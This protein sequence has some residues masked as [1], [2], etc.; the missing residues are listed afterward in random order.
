MSQP[1]KKRSPLVATRTRASSD[2][3]GAQKKSA[4]KPPKRPAKTPTKSRQK[5]PKQGGILRRLTR[6]F[7][8]LIWV[9]ASRSALVV[10]MMIV[11][12]TAYFYTQLPD[13]PDFADGRA[14]GSVT[15][16]DRYGLPFAW[17]GQNYGGAVDAQSV[18]PHL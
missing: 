12:G 15:F 18:S 14:Q 16:M 1:P 13:L 17:R 4:T 9:I 5:A 3:P 6:G 8:W 7:G 2:K 10:A 11:A